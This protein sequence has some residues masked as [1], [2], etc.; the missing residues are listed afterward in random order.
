[1]TDHSRDGLDLRDEDRLPWLEAVEDE[2]E[3]GGVSAFKV[4]GVVLAGLLV[5]GAVIGGIYWMQ[6]RAVPA[7]GEGELI[8]APAGDYKVKPDE[9]GGMAVE[10]K[11]DAAFAAS[12]GAAP[13]G[14]ID[15]NAV[16]E[17]PVTGKAAPVAADTAK[18][19]RVATAAVP[20]TARQ[21]AVKAPA[22]AAPAAGGQRSLIGSGSVIQLGSFGSEAIANRAWAALSGRF[23]FLAPLDKVIIPATVGGK[24]YYRLR[25]ATESN[26]Q[27]NDFCGRL[28][29]GGENCLVVAN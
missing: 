19:A 24:S 25:V 28:K 2:D 9:P 6:N 14:A 27:A 7:D 23:A 3:G 10:G 17:A 15:L 16:P 4:A 22:A 29:V 20:E 13:S 26:A 1:M 11:G 12:D 8:A 21:L 5:L 18:A